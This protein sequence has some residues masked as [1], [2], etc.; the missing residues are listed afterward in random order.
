MALSPDSRQLYA[1]DGGLK[2]FDRDAASGAL[3]QRTQCFRADGQ[4]GCATGAGLL[5]ARAV[6]ASPDGK[7]V[8]VGS[9][10]GIAVFDRASDGSLT[11]KSGPDACFGDGACQPAPGIFTPSAIAIS[12]DGTT[13]YALS[14]ASV[15]VFDR[16]SDG[17]L[18]QKAG[19]NGCITG[20]V[21]AGCAQAVGLSGLRA[22]AVSPDGHNVYLGSTGFGMIL[23]FDRAATGTL[24]ASGCLSDAAVAG[25]TTGDRITNPYALAVSPDGRNVYS[26]S[27]GP[28]DSGI[29][30]LDRDP[31]TG[32]LSQAPA[33]S[34]DG[35]VGNGNDPRCR[36]A[37]AL[38]PVYDVAVSGDGRNV[39]AA[40]LEGIAVFDRVAG[41]D[42]SQ[43]PM[44]DGCLQDRGF[45][46]QTGCAPADDITET[47]TMVIAPDGGSVYTASPW[48]HSIAA[49]ARELPPPATTPQ[50]AP[51]PAGTP[52][53]ALMTRASTVTELVAKLRSRSF[54]S[55]RGKAFRVAY[56]STIRGT[57]TLQVLK[58]RKRVLTMKSSTGK[59]FRI[60]EKLARGKYRI[61]LTLKAAGQTAGDSAKLTVR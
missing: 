33:P 16:H 20:G 4:Q 12:P 60:A 45:A 51:L 19:N 2:V 28:G 22:I 56:V 38:D 27:W 47:R 31:A 41:G 39:Y 43:K 10:D 34:I 37:V 21:V 59:A 1:V 14:S 26:A 54:K 8:Y 36:L 23:T 18:V 55:K 35:C 5:S 6:T 30:I 61:K 11:Q 46:M 42:L 25:C 7:N 50:T 17:S 40:T 32:A 49:F 3:T 53:P 44:P 24:T 58:G 13:V 29:A 48:Y 57:A 52:Q 15:A 9:A